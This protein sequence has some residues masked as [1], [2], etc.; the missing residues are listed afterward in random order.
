VK[1]VSWRSPGPSRRELREFQG[2]RVGSAITVAP[3]SARVLV[4]D[5]ESSTSNATR[6]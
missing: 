1:R 3:A 6:M 5:G 2:V 4:I